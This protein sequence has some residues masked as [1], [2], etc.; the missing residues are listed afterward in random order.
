M[1]H[2]ILFFVTLLAMSLAMQAQVTGS[3]EGELKVG[4]R[5]SL[6]IVFH[7]DETEDGNLTATMDSPDQ[8]V[9]G[10]PVSSVS[11]DTSVQLLALS[12][13]TLNINYQGKLTNDA[14]KG[15]FVQNAF[16]IPLTLTR[17]TT[18]V[19]EPEELPYH[20][21]EVKI[22][23]PSDPS[24]ILSGTL[25]QPKDTGCYPAVVLIAGSGPNNRDSQIYG[26]K[27]LYDIADYL[28]R[29]GVIVLRY[30]K[31]GIGQ[32]TGEYRLSMTTDFASDASAALQYLKTL[33]NVTKVGLIGH[34]E[35]GLIAQMI[36]AQTPTLPDFIVMLAAPGITGLETIVFQNVEAI[37]GLVEPDSLGAFEQITREFF[38][39]IQ[40]PD[41]SRVE[42]SL[43]MQS[44]NKRVKELIASDKMI[45]VGD[46]FDNEERLSSMLDALTTPFYKAFLRINPADYLPHIQCPVL[47]L[48]GEK[49]MQ[50]GVRDNLDAIKSLTT[51]SSRLEV[52]SYPDLNHLFIPAV[53]GSPQEYAMLKEPFSTEVLADII[54]FIRSVE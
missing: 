41:R 7:I 17:Q 3:W 4:S 11:F 51:Q 37:S 24:I 35:G 54:A 33:P 16:P 14:I 8:G 2:R 27:P 46:F 48:N 19:V 9:A 44:Y 23:N 22:S 20:Q 21:E 52:K 45:M 39:E 31:R 12:V 36:A 30:D 18:K 40:L 50:V 6:T 15:H 43:A 5:Y 25:T 47:A 34:S 13:E 49:D 38:E 53:T 1:K 28:T 29:R 32:S 42:D 10:I 26:H